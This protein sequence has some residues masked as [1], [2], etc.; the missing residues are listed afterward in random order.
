VAKTQQFD[1]SAVPVVGRAISSAC[2]PPPPRTTR[3]G[4]PFPSPR[5]TS[6]EL[7]AQGFLAC[8]SARKLSGEPVGPLAFLISL[9][10]QL[11]AALPFGFEKGLKG[12]PEPDQRAVAIKTA[13]SRNPAVHLPVCCAEACWMTRPPYAALTGLAAV[14]TENSRPDKGVAG[15]DS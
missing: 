5:A 8:R 9:S 4:R 3:F 10:P 6:R 1:L 11:V 2:D 13:G 15:G 7:R 12:H 14:R